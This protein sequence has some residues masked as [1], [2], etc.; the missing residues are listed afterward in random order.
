MKIQL[1]DAGYH[2]FTGDFGGVQF[3]DGVS[4]DDVSQTQ[5]RFFAAVMGVRSVEDG[6]DPGSNAQFVASLELSAVTTNL[7]TLAELEANGIDHGV[8]VQ[9]PQVS[10][11]PVPVGKY[12]QEQLEEIADKGGMSKLREI[13]NQFGVKGTSIAKLIESILAKQTAPQPEAAPLAEGQ[14]DVVTSEQA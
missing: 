4:V 9:A 12:T 13:G 7:P 2:K 8:D 14:P 3:V 5:A 10:A 11:P 6:S 1:I